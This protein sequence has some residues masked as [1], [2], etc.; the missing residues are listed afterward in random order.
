MAGL[1]II[2]PNQAKSRYQQE[3]RKFD[4]DL[5]SGQHNKDS[6]AFSFQEA[7]V[8]NSKD[9]DVAVSYSEDVQ[10]VKISFKGEEAGEKSV[11]NI[12][13]RV[14]KDTPAVKDSS[15]SGEFD[16]VLD[17]SPAI[18]GS[19]NAGMMGL[20]KKSKSESV[21]VSLRSDA[22]SRNNGSVQIRNIVSQQSSDQYVDSVKFLCDQIEVEIRSNQELIELELEEPE[23]G[24][25]TNR[26]AII[27]SHVKKNIEKREFDSEPGI[28]VSD[29]REKIQQKVESVAEPESRQVE[30]G[31][32]IK[33]RPVPA[34]VKAMASGKNVLGVSGDKASPAVFGSLKEVKRLAGYDLDAKGRPQLDS[35]IYKKVMVE[36]VV[37]GLP[38][39]KYVAVQYD[40]PE[41][42][43]KSMVKGQPAKPV[44]FKV[45]NKKNP[46]NRSFKVDA[47]PKDNIDKMDKDAEKVSKLLQRDKRAAEELGRENVKEA[48]NNQAKKMKSNERKYIENLIN[49]SPKEGRSSLLSDVKKLKEDGVSGREI[50]R[51]VEDSVKKGPAKPA[52]KAPAAAPAKGPSR[53]PSGG[54]PAGGGSGGGY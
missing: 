52:R 16:L 21:E 31:K 47:S 19:N 4:M 25:E 3:A 10:A 41:I 36:E 27:T 12:L 20:L 26:A 50:V 30:V 42:G 33:E 8:S 15:A 6:V 14:I 34:Q 45:K 9:P 23:E 18:K 2:T 1:I 49:N 28:S 48:R 39:G 54:S 22:L 11:M 32:I 46:S 35:P 13:D 29:V 37:E 40:D 53:R 43:V 17:S 38:E 44:H 51:Y 7:S 5:G 24:Q